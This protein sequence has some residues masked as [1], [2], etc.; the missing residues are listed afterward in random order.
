[1]NPDYDIRSKELGLASKESIQALVATHIESGNKTSTF[2]FLDVRNDV[3]RADEQL[4]SEILVAHITATTSDT[5]SLDH[6]IETFFPNK[7]GEQW[8]PTFVFIIFDTFTAWCSHDSNNM[9]K[10]N[11]I[12]KDPIIVFCKSGR[13]AAAAKDKLVVLGYEHVYNAG[14]LSDLLSYL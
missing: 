9:S 5:S 4:K 1:M 3:E 11:F 7:Q 8:Y 13:R 2:L 6:N 14:G 12:M 10:K